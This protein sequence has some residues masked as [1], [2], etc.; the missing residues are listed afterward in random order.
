MYRS[1]IMRIR[2]L[3]SQGLTGDSSEKSSVTTTT[4]STTENLSVCFFFFFFLS[5]LESPENFTVKLCIILQ[6]LQVTAHNLWIFSLKNT[7]WSHGIIFVLPLNITWNS[8]NFSDLNV[9][10]MAWMSRIAECFS[11]L[12]PFL[13]FFS[14]FFFL[15]LL[16]DSPERHQRRC[17]IK[18]RVTDGSWWRFWV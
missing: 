4:R 16:P 2:E 8:Y 14:F 11:K 13:S 18:I 5:L 15:G 6:N 1:G 7:T 12:E 10:T 17:F 3:R 9:S